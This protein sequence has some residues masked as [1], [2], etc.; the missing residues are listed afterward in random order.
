MVISDPQLF[1]F[2]L[3]LIRILLAQW[4]QQIYGF[5]PFIDLEDAPGYFGQHLRHILWL[6]R[7]RYRWDQILILLLL[8]ELVPIG[9]D[10]LRPLIFILVEAL[11]KLGFAT[12]DLMEPFTLIFIV[13]FEIILHTIILSFHKL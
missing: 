3:I 5:P 2:L 13:H 11:F 1:C 8:L 7:W 4:H 6:R 12:I 9:L 10:L